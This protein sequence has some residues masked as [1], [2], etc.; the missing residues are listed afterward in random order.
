M[1]MH[2]GSLFLWWLDHIEIRVKY[3][4][5]SILTEAAPKVPHPN[6]PGDSPRG[7][8]PLITREI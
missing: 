3:I 8:D 4:V 7:A 2:Y 6:P 5:G 1:L